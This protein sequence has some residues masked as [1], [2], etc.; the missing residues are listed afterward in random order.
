VG[1]GKCYESHRCVQSDDF[2]DIYDE[3]VCTDILLIVSPHYAPIPAK[4]AALLEKMEQITFLHWCKDNAWRSEVFGKPVGIISHGGGGARALKSYKRMVNDTIANALDT[5][6]LK[7]VSLNSK[8]DTGISIPVKKAVFNKGSVFP[9]QEY[10]W[11][12]IADT[13]S[14][15]LEAVR[16]VFGR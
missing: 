9:S 15:Y 5:I 6:Q 4:L 3:I 10:D 8:W 13:V 14:N 12:L 7:P 16:E 11:E 1:C 2:N